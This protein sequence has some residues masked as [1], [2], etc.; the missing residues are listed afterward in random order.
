M[1]RTLCYEEDLF[2]E[3]LSYTHT[4]VCTHA[5]RYTHIY[6]HTHTH[7]THACTHTHTH[8]HTQANFIG[9]KKDHTQHATVFT[10]FEVEALR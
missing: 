1:F 7:S 2:Y 5:R 6:T 10:H 4:H 3:A 8:T 9:L